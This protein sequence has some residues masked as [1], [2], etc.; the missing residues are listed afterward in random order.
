M[1][2]L[3]LLVEHGQF[4]IAGENALEFGPGHLGKKLAVEDWNSI[5]HGPFHAGK[6]RIRIRPVPPGVVHLELYMGGKIGEG[7]VH[8]IGSKNEIN[9]VIGAVL[10]RAER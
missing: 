9:H 1:P 6:E 8:T 4:D 10:S 5:V 2:D 7:C 3:H